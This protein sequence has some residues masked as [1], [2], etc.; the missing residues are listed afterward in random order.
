M[1]YITVK[2]LMPKARVVV[3]HVMEKIPV[4]GVSTRIKGFRIVC[5]QEDIQWAIYAVMLADPQIET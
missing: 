5:S 1:F 4:N 3:R 2:F